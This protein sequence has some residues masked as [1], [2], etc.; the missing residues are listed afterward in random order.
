MDA[1]PRVIDIRSSLGLDAEQVAKEIAIETLKRHPQLQQTL[2]V[3]AIAEDAARILEYLSLAIEHDEKSLFKEYICWAGRVVVARGVQKSQ[4]AEQVEV[5][6]EILAQKL[7]GPLAQQ[8]LEIGLPDW[9][10]ILK[11]HRW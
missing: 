1:L 10:R 9:R 4:F 11:D 2:S 6:Q 8:A 7:R 5:S 3:R